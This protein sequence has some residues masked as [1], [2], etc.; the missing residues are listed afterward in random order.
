MRSTILIIET[1][2]WKFNKCDFLK[3]RN[4]CQGLPMWLIAL[5]VK[6]CSCVTDHILMNREIN[7]L[8][9]GFCFAE[10]CIFSIFSQILEM[11]SAERGNGHWPTTYIENR[12]FK[13][14]M[15]NQLITKPGMILVY[16]RLEEH[17][18]SFNFRHHF[19]LSKERH[20]PTALLP[21]EIIMAPITLCR[22]RGVRC[23]LHAVGKSK[24][25]LRPREKNLDS[26][27]VLPTAYSLY[28]NW[29]F[30]LPNKILSHSIIDWTNIYF[31]QRKCE[32][33]GHRSVGIK[34]N[35]NFQWSYSFVDI[36]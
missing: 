32:R 7:T 6:K 1:K 11:N 26:M 35:H 9:K 8:L 30:I 29:L 17:L 20:V 28:S 22:L 27:A 25:S 14:H 12:R 33:V 24:I 21:G 10:F 23:R 34:L 5:I 36:R 18:Q 16:R 31:S 15:L 4:F 13:S 2:R 19:M 3:N